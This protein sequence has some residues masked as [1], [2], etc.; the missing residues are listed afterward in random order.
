MS[1]VSRVTFVGS[2]R[3]GLQVLK[4]MHGLSPDVLAGV[5]TL[6]DRA[7]TRSVFAELEGYCAGQGIHMQV[8][9]DRRDAEAAISARSPD[10]CVVVGWYWLISAAVLAAVPRGFIGIHNSV[11]PQYR[12]GAPLVWQLI[13]RERHVGASL[14]SFTPGMDD[15]PIWAQAI[16]PVQEDDYIGDVLGK[17]EDAT[18]AAFRDCYPRILDGAAR[19]VEQDHAKATYCAQRV[20]E[21]GA[22][23]WRAPAVQVG[24]FIRA[25]S[26]PYP[27]AF[28]QLDGRRLTI[29][30]ADVFKGVYHGTPGQV[31]RI[32]AEGVYVVCGDSTALIVREAQLE[33]RRAPANELIRSLSGRLA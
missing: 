9:R 14:F 11:L 20:P 3:L 27:G 23:D 25:Q 28:T 31:A 10:L 18:L 7:D 16:V 26:D 2:K 4:C 6:D 17:L 30:R 33:G 8:A 32:A 1:A 15:G 13:R 21:D 22:I 19:P 29:W 12:G 24:A 5:I